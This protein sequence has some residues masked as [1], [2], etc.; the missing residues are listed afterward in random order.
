MNVPLIYLASPY[1]SSKSTELRQERYEA[2]LAAETEIRRGGL[3]VYSPIVHCHPGAARGLYPSN[4]EYWQAFDELMLSRCDMLYVLT[5][6]G[7]Q[8]SIGVQ[9]E[10]RLAK[11]LNKPT[12][13]VYPLHYLK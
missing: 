3:H 5:L 13:L 1:G 10:I 6:D 4:W 12:L 7:W 2:A 9:A 8:E 11:Q